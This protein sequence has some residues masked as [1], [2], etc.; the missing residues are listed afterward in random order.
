VARASKVQVSLCSIHAAFGC[1]PPDEAESG[2]GQWTFFGKRV[3]RRKIESL[4]ERLSAILAPT[5]EHIVME[6]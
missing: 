5:F 2:L 1:E 6:K 3:D 4:V